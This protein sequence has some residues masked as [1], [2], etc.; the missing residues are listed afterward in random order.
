[1]PTRPDFIR[2][3]APQLPAALWA[4]RPA[5]QRRR[6]YFAWCER[7]RSWWVDGIGHERATQAWGALVAARIYNDA[8]E[9][10]VIG[11][12]GGVAVRAT[13]GGMAVRGWDEPTWRAAMRRARAARDYRLR[14][15]NPRR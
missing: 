5:P 11:K 2:P 8:R 14:R 9:P 6:A 10:L 7:C 1:M 15:A 12:T 4:A 13:A 3:A